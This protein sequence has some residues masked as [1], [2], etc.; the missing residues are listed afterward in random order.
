MSIRDLPNDIEALRAIIRE[1]EAA[2]AADRAELDQA[3]AGLLEQR[4]EIEALRARLARLLRMTFGRS[5]EKLQ[6][7]IEQL[8]LTLADLDES[9]AATAPPDDQ[10]DE[11]AEMGRKP[12]R[13]PLAAHLPRTVVEHLAPCSCPTCGGALRPLGEDVTEILDYVPG[14]FRV[15]RHVRPKFSCRACETIAQAPA[16][17]LPVRRGRA[18]AGLLAH[19]LVAKYADHLPL[20]RQAE[21]YAREDVDLCR[22]TLAD[23]VG[24]TARLVRPL[25][26][27]L[28][29]HVMS[30]E[31]L[32]AD[33]TVVPV[34]E[35]G[36]GRTRQA[37]LWTYVRD[38]RPFGGSDP[39]AV[40][41]RYSP[42]RKGEHPRAHLKGFAGILQADGYSGFKSLYADGRI[43][44]ASC[45]AHARRGFFEA[46]EKTQS[47]LVREA[48]ERIGALYRVEEFVRGRTPGQRLVLRGERSA[49][50]MG[51]LRTWL[52]ATLIRISGRS[53]LAK[54]IRY[55]LARW[56]GLTNV[57]R[58][59]RV[60]IDNAAAE[61]A[62]RPI[63][64]GRR[65]WT[66]A[67]SDAGGA[68]AA[69]IYSLI[70]TA[71]IN[72]IDP[73]DYL[74]HMLERIADYPVGQVADLL[75]W[76]MVGLKPRLD[77]RIAA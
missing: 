14:S 44:E 69:A 41:Y 51:E 42:D 39:P 63:A 5:S 31:R 40:L 9:L 26:D 36:R 10:T 3:R 58:D 37:R 71:K 32:H 1:Q 8:E 30:A 59:G 55:A 75:P 16:P 50:L 68:R 49:P 52:D 21:I 76:N 4:F 13:R 43:T 24:Q 74:R 67:G 23:M 35:P 66:F 47:P 46:Y 19:V 60:C 70:E 18:G 25:V 2:R 33:D 38:D 65:N 62:M 72:G 12:A 61:R 54:A 6:T 77:Q 11:P 22:S 28:A 7:Q 15:I 45:W 73:E 48:L 56:D 53:E 20:H 27:A 17:S 34:L 57:L 29:R 64:I